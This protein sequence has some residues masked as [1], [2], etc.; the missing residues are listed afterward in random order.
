MSCVDPEVM[1]LFRESDKIVN[2]NIIK[3]DV[4]YK[5]TEV[6]YNVLAKNVA[7]RLDIM[8][9]SIKAVINDFEFVRANKIQELSECIAEEPNDL[10]KELL[11]FYKKDL[12]VYKDNNFKNY[13]DAFR[14]IT[15]SRTSPECY[16][17]ENPNSS[18]LIY[19]I[20][21][22][23]DFYW[24]F[25]CSDIRCLFRAIIEAS[26]KNAY[27]KLDVS[28]LVSIGYYGIDEKICTDALNALLSSYPCN[29]KIIILTE[30]ITD[31]DV[32]AQSLELLYPHLYEYYSFMDFSFSP[33]GGAGNLVN[34]LKSFSGAGIKNK[35]LALFDNDTA[36]FSAVKSLKAIQ[37]PD[38]IKILHYPDIDLAKKYPT[39]GPHGIHI[40]DINGLACSIELYFGEDVLKENGTLTPVQWKGLDNGIKKHQ[41]VIKNKNKLKQKF[42]K[43]LNKCQKSHSAINPREWK[44]ID[45]ILN[46]IFNATHV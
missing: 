29:S 27:V 18:K 35:I 11:P 23:N 14:T 39:T 1:T 31:K 10:F 41:G 26:P 15:K 3:D 38:N 30:G 5:Q 24:G 12:S 45:L 22:K 34:L 43:K 42:M 25:P 19:Y 36:A 6:V 44:D 28:D 20:L 16:L 8:G 9:F 2:K 33:Q 7:Q 46:C 40:Q 37:L 32:I 4:E 13:L 17:Q 21:N